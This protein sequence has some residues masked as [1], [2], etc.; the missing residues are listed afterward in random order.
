MWLAGGVKPD[1]NTISDFRS[2]GLKDHL[3]KV[4][5]QVV[6]LLAEQGVLSLKEL[7]LDGTNISGEANRYT[8][9]W[10]KAIKVS[11]ERIARQLRELWSYV[12]EVY[13]DEEQT[14]HEPDIEKIDPEAVESA[15]REIN[16]ALR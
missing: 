7:T 3:K 12:E 15:I 16:E 9:V 10:G 1:H 5:G 14:R 4:F 8:F 6:V 13:R 2:K 11:R